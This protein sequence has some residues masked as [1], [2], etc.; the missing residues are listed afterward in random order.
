MLTLFMIPVSAPASI[1]CFMTATGPYSAANMRA[2]NPFYEIISHDV[3]Y[4]GRS[5]YSSNN[6]LQEEV[7]SVLRI[8][9]SL[10]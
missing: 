1:R 5:S 2:E 10:H 6:L 9:K 3:F 8:L 4:E 7:P